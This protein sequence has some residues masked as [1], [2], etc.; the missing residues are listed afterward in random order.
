VIATCRFSGAAP[1]DDHLELDVKLPRS[2]HMPWPHLSVARKHHDAAL[3]H[4]EAAL[5]WEKYGD[6]EHAESGRV[7]IAVAETKEGRRLLVL[8]LD[9]E[10][11]NRLL[12]DQP[13]LSRLDEV[14]V[15]G[16]EEWDV[17][18]LGPEDTVRFV[19][20]LRAGK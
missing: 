4:E 2:S 9:E 17:T 7:L 14:P 11:V 18:I 1:G 6:P 15:P 13:I 20:H 8:G 12:N 3:R 10:N 5:H 16:L 19:A